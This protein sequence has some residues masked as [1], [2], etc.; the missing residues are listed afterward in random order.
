MGSVLSASGRVRCRLQVGLKFAKG[1]NEATDKERGD[2]AE[3]RSFVRDRSECK[4]EADI[5]INE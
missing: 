5:R 3:S 2:Y 1:E 4:I